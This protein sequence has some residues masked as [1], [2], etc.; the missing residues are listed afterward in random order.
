MR[1]KARLYR[2]R[3]GVNDLL[4]RAELTK[5]ELARRS[6]VDRFV[7]NDKVVEGKHARGVIAWK[8]A[9]GYAEATGINEEDA[10]ARLWEPAE[11]TQNITKAPSLAR[12]TTL[13]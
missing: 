4:D 7:I 11:G 12:A 10:F 13:F 8:I 2:I 5:A 6:G 1:Q 3:D 9:R